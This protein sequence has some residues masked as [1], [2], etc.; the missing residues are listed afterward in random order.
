MSRLFLA[1]MEG[2]VDE[3][4]RATLTEA[5]PYDACV[6]E[7]A[8]VAGSALPAKFFTRI[9]PELHT[10]SRTAAGTPVKVQLLGSDPGRL[11]E[12]ALTL[13]QLAPA[14]IDLNFG[15]PAPTVNRHRGGAVLLDEPELLHRI[16]LAV[17]AAVPPSMPVTAKMRLGMR[18]TSRA[19]EAACALADGGAGE[20]V[21]HARTK[22]DGY[23][24]PAH[25]PWIARIAE[26]VSVPVIANGEVWTL[27]DYRR[28]RSESGRCDVMLGRG[29]VADPFLVERIRA[30]Q[31]GAVVR[32]HDEDW[33]RLHPLIERFWARVL[34]KVE[35]RHAPGRL[36][37]WLNLLRRHY[38][39][40]GLLYDAI[41]PLRDPAAVSNVLQQAVVLA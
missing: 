26:A 31:A 39:Q 41:R 13:A 17:R 23:R 38:A 15:C 28:C 40:A 37:Q 8:R 5:A 29:A 33:S 7:F 20:L 12:S 4:M 14:G 2:L 18:D 9:A 22:E 11:A 10:R 16:L 32:S 36:K 21:V 24:P 19:L 6:T 30:A 1:P 27:D 35:P 25:W 34:D 3:V